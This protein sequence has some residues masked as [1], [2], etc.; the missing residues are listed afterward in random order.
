MICGATAASEFRE[1]GDRQ[2][3]LQDRPVVCDRLAG[4]HYPTVSFTP[5]HARRQ[6]RKLHSEKA[7]GPNGVRS[8]VLK[9]KVLK[10]SF[11]ECFTVSSEGPCAAEDILPRS[12]VEE[13]VSQW[14]QVLQ[15]GGTDVPHHNDPGETHS[16]A[17]QAH[18]QAKLGSPPVRLPAL[19]RCWGRHH[20]PAESSLRPP[21]QAD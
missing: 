7:A 3:R 18:G 5:H 14:L 2:W 13:I 9:A 6:L 15:T 17:A 8:K 1:F 20:L 19:A 10:A 12:C 16:G 11:V 21:G 4:E